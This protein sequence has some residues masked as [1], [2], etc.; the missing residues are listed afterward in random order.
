[1]SPLDVVFGLIILAMAVRCALKGFVDE[2]MTVAAVLGGIIGGLLLSGV[3]ADFLEKYVGPFYLSSLIGFLLVFIVFYLAMK[4]FENALHRLVDRI[5]LENLDRALGLFLGL[6]E[7]AV[8][9]L[10]IIFVMAVQPIADTSALLEE[11]FI[12]G[13]GLKLI[14]VFQEQIVQGDIG[15]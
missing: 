4:L 2:F 13:I 11:S 6:V 14:P 7:G 3:V 10:F 9:V 5:N 1:M 12:G 8:I 15:V